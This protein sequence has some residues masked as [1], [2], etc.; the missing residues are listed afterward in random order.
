MKITIASW[1]LL[2]VEVVVVLLTTFGIVT[3]TYRTRQLFSQ[4]EDVRSEQEA[5]LE[6]WGK[7]LL[8]ESAFSSPSRVERVARESLEMRLP[9][10][11]DMLELNN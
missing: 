4:L 6:R 1:M 9:S 3:T 2:L 8:E 11:D 7:L 10:A 5:Q